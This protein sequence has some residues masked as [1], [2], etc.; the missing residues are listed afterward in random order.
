MHTS[1]TKLEQMSVWKV[2]P[3]NPLSL[4]YS[5]ELKD[6]EVIVAYGPEANTLLLFGPRAA[7]Q[8][9][10]SYFHNYN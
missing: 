4:V 8:D 5:L 2:E 3:M 7:K 1:Y 10:K 9:S 6:Q